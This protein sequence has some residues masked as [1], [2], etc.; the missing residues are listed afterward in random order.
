MSSPSPPD[1]PLELIPEVI[2]EEMRGAK[3]EKMANTIN[4]YSDLQIMKCLLTKNF[5]EIGRA[6]ED[7]VITKV[8]PGAFYQATN[9]DSIV[10]PSVV[11]IGEFAFSECSAGTITLPWA[12]IETIRFGAFY[13]CTSAGMP[14]AVSF[15]K[16]TMID[17]VA[18]AGTSDTPNTW[19]T[20]ISLPVWTGS[21]PSNTK[22]TVTSTQGIF[23]Y[24]TALTSASLPELVTVP[25]KLFYRA[26]A[27]QEI[28]LPKCTGF[29]QDCFAY[30]TSLKKLDIGGAVS[31]ISNNYITGDTAL[32][33]L[34]LR[35]I[36][37]VPTLSANAFSGTRIASG[38]AYVYVPRSLEATVK[39]A[40]NW[41]NYS[42]QIRAIEDYPAVCGS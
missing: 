22:F 31:A 8:K 23:E 11:D 34:I 13:K 7:N 17:Q 14:S 20:S 4:S 26:S 33:A 21:A 5:S 28:V 35:G 32:E 12:D 29:S 16:A 27:I 19:L 30:C 25:K 6:F 36:T 2:R 40:A 24:C 37:V 1:T 10:L 18:F 38:A 39:V 3:E 41:T 15:A 42:A 9:L